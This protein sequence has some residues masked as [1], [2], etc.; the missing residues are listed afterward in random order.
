MD[1]IIIESCAQKAIGLIRPESV[2]AVI[3]SPPYWA[4]RNYQSADQFGQEKTPDEW[5]DRLVETFAMVRRILRPDG[6]V[7]LN[8]GD[9]YIQDGGRRKWG[10]RE[11]FE[12]PM[13]LSKGST[14]LKLKN[15]AL[16]PFRLALKLQEDGWI[17]RQVIIWEKPNAVPESVK[18]RCT[19][20]HEYIF[21]MAKS[22][23]YY[24]DHKAIKEPAIWAG[25]RERAMAGKFRAKSEPLPGR[26]PFRA[27]ED[28]KNKRSVWTVPTRKSKL[29]HS[30][31][32]PPDLVRPMIQAAT[33][34]GDIVLDPFM[35]S[36]TTLLVAKEL[37]RQGIGIEINPEFIQL[38]KSRLRGTP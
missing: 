36:G 32:F 16:S 4:L 27:I 24:F 3:T 12:K 37:G 14:G 9:T 30:A 29:K 38:A 15:L 5:A 21:L 22:E 17:F 7:W 20:S 10:D 13:R 18:D 26:L 6:T 28:F 34:P 25:K 19:T 1:P 8:V 31:M 11:Q 35:G 2:Q 23:K 33:R